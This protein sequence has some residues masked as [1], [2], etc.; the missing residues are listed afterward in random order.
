MLQAHSQCRNTSL[1]PTTYAMQA[2]EA[3]VEL[4]ALL[5]AMQAELNA[6]ET[7]SFATATVTDFS[8]QRMPEVY[9]HLI[10]ETFSLHACK[11][12]VMVYL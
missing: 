2:K 9:Y 7:K 11:V 3:L 1:L 8:Y 5:H 6:I 10:S 12:S 4:Q